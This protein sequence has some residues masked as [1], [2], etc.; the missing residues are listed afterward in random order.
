MLNLK[1][2]IALNKQQVVTI[3]TSP[4]LYRTCKPK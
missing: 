4:M 3:A 2:K 1:I